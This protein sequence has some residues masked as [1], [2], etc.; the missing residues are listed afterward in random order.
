MS[1]CFAASLLPVVFPQSLPFNV[2]PRDLLRPVPLP[3]G[4]CH[5]DSAQLRGGPRH[6]QIAQDPWGLLITRPKALRLRVVRTGLHLASP[7][8]N[9]LVLSEYWRRSCLEALLYVLNC[10]FQKFFFITTQPAT[11][12][13]S[14][15]TSS[16]LITGGGCVAVAVPSLLRLL[17]PASPSFLSS[18]GSA[19]LLSF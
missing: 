6:H 2:S 8:K 15:T 3:R 4:G 5:R 17:P 14:H 7:G 12:S 9:L 13:V 16:A 11:S 19:D 10:N 18:H 1:R